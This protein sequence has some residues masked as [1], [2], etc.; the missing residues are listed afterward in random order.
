MTL[1]LQQDYTQQLQQLMQRLGF[2]SYKQLSQSCGVSQKQLRRLRSGQLLQM[3]VE[4]LL[5]LAQALQVSV[6]ELLEM[7]SSASAQLN[8]AAD[9]TETSTLLERDAAQTVEA[10]RQEYQRLQQ[11]L[12][13]Q[14]ETLIQE[15]QQSSLRVLEPWLVQWPTAA[16]AAQQNQQLPAVRLLPLV[17]PV[18]QLLQE[19]GVEAIASVGSELAYDPQWHQLMEGTAQP[20]ES[21]RV[22]YAGY[23]LRGNLLY[24]TKVS[25]VS[26]TNK[27]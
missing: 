10:L 19:W 14:R 3:R 16:Y 4:T 17:R 9:N 5:K 7:F 2:S 15:F 11:Q 23:R 27:D 12:E 24:R 1:S 13:N 21:V 18:E 26:N 20:G 8:P 25:P 22:R 6:S